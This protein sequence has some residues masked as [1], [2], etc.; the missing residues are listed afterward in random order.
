GTR[1]VVAGSVQQANE[2]RQPFVD[3]GL[4]HTLVAPAPYGD[5]RMVAKA[6][7][8]V[9]GVVEKQLRILRFDVV[10]LSGLPEI[11]P[12]EQPVL[13]GEIVENLFRVLPHPVAN[14]VQVCITVQTEIRLEPLARDSLPR[15]VHSPISTTTGD[16][17]PVDLDYKIRCGAGI[18][19]D[20]ER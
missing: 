12:D 13:V 16:S 5:G 18:G 10:V 9:A 11:I 15:I 19:E 3:N 2:F 14:D 1:R 8:C 7:N 6:K 17:H 4:G 20:T